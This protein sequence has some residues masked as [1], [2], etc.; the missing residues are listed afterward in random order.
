MAQRMPSGMPKLNA[1]FLYLA[2]LV[3]IASQMSG[4]GDSDSLF[5]EG[6]MEQGA[7]SAEVP[8]EAPEPS[9]E[10]VDEEVDWFGRIH[11]LQ[12]FASPHSL[13]AGFAVHAD[14]DPSG[15]PPSELEPPPPEC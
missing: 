10:R 5:P 1:F 6:R 13:I 8:G 11:H 15:I 14:D 2:F 7:V 12:F 3:S 4:W 9:D